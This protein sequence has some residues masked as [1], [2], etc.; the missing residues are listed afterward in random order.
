M[1]YF[2]KSKDW[3]MGFSLYKPIND[4]SGS[5]SRVTK[6]TL[7]AT[8]RDQRASLAEGQGLEDKA[9]RFS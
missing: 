1:F 7:D 8:C 9:S 6:V 3:E 2:L 4:P 5:F